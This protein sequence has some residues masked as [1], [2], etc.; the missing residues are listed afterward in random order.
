M[1][2]FNLVLSVA[3][4]GLC[5]TAQSIGSAGDTQYGPNSAAGY[6]VTHFGGAAPL[7][8]VSSLFTLVC[9]C[10]LCV[11]CPSATLLCCLHATDHVTWGSAIVAQ[12]EYFLQ[13]ITKR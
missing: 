3:A 8:A 2:S 5:A 12:V 9:G 4:C 6:A 10:G 11:V 13:S 7:A 1:L